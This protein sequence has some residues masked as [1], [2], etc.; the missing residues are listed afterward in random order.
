MEREREAEKKKCNK[1]KGFRDEEHVDS[2]F[3]G[4]PGTRN[5]KC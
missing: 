1:I 2:R 3:T 5:K 4:K